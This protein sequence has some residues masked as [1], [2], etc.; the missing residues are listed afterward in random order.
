MERLADDDTVLETLYVT[1]QCDTEKDSYPYTPLPAFSNH[2][3]DPATK[4][5]TVTC[6]DGENYTFPAAIVSGTQCIEVSSTGIYRVTEVTS[7]SSTD[8]DFW[9][10]SEKFIPKTGSQTTGEPNHAAN[11]PFVTFRITDTDTDKTDCATVSFTNT[12]TEYAYLS[13]QAYAENTIKRSGS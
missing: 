6:A 12:E 2:S 13:S 10:G 3:Y 5:V 11:D 9:T 4:K 7:W 1:I 8:Y